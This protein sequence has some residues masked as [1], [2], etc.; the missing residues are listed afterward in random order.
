M[1][2]SAEPSDLIPEA[3]GVMLMIAYATFSPYVVLILERR[4]NIKSPNRYLMGGL[5]IVA[6]LIAITVVFR[7]LAEMKL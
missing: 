6:I 2:Q 1:L 3:I 5:R 4:F 7:L